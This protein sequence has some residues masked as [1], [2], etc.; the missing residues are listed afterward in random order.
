[1]LSQL[2]R[3]NFSTFLLFLDSSSWFI[4]YMFSN[5]LFL[6]S[7]CLAHFYTKTFISLFSEVLLILIRQL[8][9]K[10]T[11]QT[12]QK[13]IK[14]PQSLMLAIL[15]KIRELFRWAPPQIPSDNFLFLVS[16]TFMQIIA[17]IV[18]F[19]RS[20]LTFSQ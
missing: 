7:A 19:L 12:T 5:Q 4:Y 13:P 14:N 1:M 17:M 20:V 11:T 3:C 16:P 10:E 18:F 2:K 15:I 6:S 8:P 9:I